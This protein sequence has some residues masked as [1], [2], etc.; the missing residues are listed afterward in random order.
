MKAYCFA[1]G[2]IEFGEKPPKGAIVIASGSA[3]V[4]R[5][6]ISA[7]ARHAYDGKT[8][9]VPGVPETGCPIAAVAALRAFCNWIKPNFQD[10]GLTVY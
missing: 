3:N 1:S 6:Q 9:L 5:E 7:T 10:A 4:L 2:E 8:L